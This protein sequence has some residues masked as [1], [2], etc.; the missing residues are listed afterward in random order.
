[1]NPYKDTGPVNIGLPLFP[2]ESIVTILSQLPEAE[3]GVVVERL[4]GVSA[5]LSVLQ[6]ADNAAETIEVFGGE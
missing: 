5:G 3:R 1:M 4:Q 2:P 6:A